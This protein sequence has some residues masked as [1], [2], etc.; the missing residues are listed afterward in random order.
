MALDIDML[1]DF[2]DE[3]VRPQMESVEGVS[4]IEIS[5]GSRR[6]VQI[7]V[8][9]AKLAQRGISLIDVRNAI[10]QRNQDSSAG[11]IEDDKSCY[12]LR[13]VGRFEQ[14]NELENLIIQ[15]INNTNV[16]L[17]DVAE[18]KLDHFERRQLSYANGD[19][20]LG[21]AVRRSRWGSVNTWYA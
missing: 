15:R 18:I 3:V 4:Q 16:Y 2:A 10:V 17:K 7:M 12:L 11:D 9:P 14:V 6:Q 5:G 19:R 1:Y 20:N 21:L 8:D 13:V